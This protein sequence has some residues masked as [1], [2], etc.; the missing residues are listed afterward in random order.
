MSAAKRV[1]KLLREA[2]KRATS[3]VNLQS[4]SERQK[5]EQLKESTAALQKEEVF[6]KATG[7]AIDKAMNVGKWFDAKEDYTTRVKTGSVLVVDDVVED[8]GMKEKLNKKEKSEQNTTANHSVDDK[9]SNLPDGSERK[10]ND[11]AA[12]QQSRG[13]KKRPIVDDDTELPDSRTRW[14]KRVEI[15]VSLK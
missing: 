1:Q 6:I 5:L 11:A 2:E 10:D 4:K 14:V 9:A 15:A 13:K 12:P 7:R 8:E 3:K